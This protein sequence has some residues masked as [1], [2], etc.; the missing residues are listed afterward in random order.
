MPTK[1]RIFTSPR[2]LGETLTA[3]NFPLSAATPRSVPEIPEL[4]N[5]TV[6]SSPKARQYAM[7]ADN[8]DEKHRGGVTYAHQDELPK[9]PIPDLDKS[10][11]RYLA[12]LKPLQSPREHAET[13]HAVHEFLRNEG[14]ELNEKLKR[15]AEG[16]TSYIEQFCKT[17]SS[18]QLKITL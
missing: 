5:P 12:A 7:S 14:P 3:P 10:C 4:S 2:S 8:H 16:K 11:E 1:V 15:Y 17:A 18:L 6:S 9:L 13:R